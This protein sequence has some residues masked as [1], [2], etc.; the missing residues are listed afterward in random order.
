MFAEA[1]Q[2]CPGI[3]DDTPHA[4]LPYFDLPAFIAS[5]PP[6]VPSDTPIDLVFTEFIQTQV[7]ETLNQVQTARNFTTAD[8]Q[9]YSS[10]DTSQT[11]GVFAQEK[12][13]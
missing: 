10:V 9:V 2:A 11:L 7:L 1:N 5:P 13:N 3:G 6:D 8:I 12:W 4:P